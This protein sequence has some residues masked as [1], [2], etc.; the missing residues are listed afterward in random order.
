M[1]SRSCWR[2]LYSES[3]Y[4]VV[5]RGHVDC[6]YIARVWIHR[7]A[8]PEQY[9]LFLGP[10]YI[11]LA[12]PKQALKVERIGTYGGSTSI[13]SLNHLIVPESRMAASS[14]SRSVIFLMAHD[15]PGIVH[16]I[17]LNLSQSALCK[18]PNDLLEDKRGWIFPSCWQ[19]WVVGTKADV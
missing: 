18:P 13:P 16:I 4:S 15:T 10:K 1:S 9:A 12:G 17:Y 5:G 14:T 2:P 6:S 11:C 3:L 19:K 8:R 7:I